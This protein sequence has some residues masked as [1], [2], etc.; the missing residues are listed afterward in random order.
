MKLF[1]TTLI[2][3]F[4]SLIA[5][6]QEK[7]DYYLPADVTYNPQ[8]PNP[9]V[10][11]GQEVGEWHLA[12]DQVLSYMKEI[13]KISDRAIIQEYARSYENRPLVN[14]IFTSP[15][16]QQNL[17]E[18]RKLHLKHAS[19]DEDI[20]NDGVPLVVKLGYSIHGNE[21][22]G[23]NSS[24]LTAYYLA[25]AQGEKIDQLLGNTIV[26]VDPCLNPDGFTRH[27]TW[28]NMHQ[29]AVGV[30]NNDN[31]Q[32]HEVWPGGRTNHYWFDLNRDYLLLVHPES[33]GRVKSYYEWLPN[34]V[35]DHHE[36]GSNSTFFFQPGVPTRNNPLTPERNYE[37]TREIAKYHARYLDKIGS[38]YFTEEEFDD[39]Y[40][41]KGSSYPDITSGVGILFEQAGFR[42]RNRQTANGVRKLS[43]AIRN[44]FTVSLSTLDAAMH[45][46]NELLDHQK[47]F[48]RKSLQLAEKDPVKAY[49]FGNENDRLKTLEMVKLLQEH[50]IDVFVNQKEIAKAGKTFSTGTSFIV[51]VK[52]KQYR[53][54]K[55]LFERV[56][57]FT[58]STFYDV[59]T[60]TLP[61]T[62]N[63]DYAEL[64]S[65]KDVQ[66]TEPAKVEKVR[67]KIIG[68]TEWCCLSDEME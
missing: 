46:K 49:V 35:T 12:Y 54:L 48:F 44:Q 61:Y 42:G 31:R 45:L 21:S 2:A 52:Q 19:P 28:A 65:V 27:S 11:F 67:G 8:I 39:Y 13:A 4:S 47:E 34:I 62:F 68:D 66:L 22:S 51:P 23:T 3:V 17:E 5:V 9:E 29:S 37:L 58:D 16:N 26:L 32:F 43:F 20:Q 56:T 50:Q 53:L 63:V 10:F 30:A 57:D 41:G 24:V 36:M 55:A 6:S 14:V 38:E 60:W 33:I 40:I 7:L 1:I 64:T 25:A 18:L 15:K 59:S